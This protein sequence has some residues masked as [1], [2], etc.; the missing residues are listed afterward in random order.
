MAS[1]RL[2]I[3]MNSSLVVKPVNHPHKH[4]HNPDMSTHLIEYMCQTP[5][6]SSIK[7]AV[8]VLTICTS[9]MVVDEDDSLQE[10]VDPSPELKAVT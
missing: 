9:R 6:T 4:G 8:V 5:D 2:I 7:F 10:L 3:D 1:K